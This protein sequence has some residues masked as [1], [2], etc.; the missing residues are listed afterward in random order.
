MTLP[1]L[2]IYGNCQAEAIA[3]SVIN[4]PG[5]ADR[6]RIQ[7]VRSY[8]ITEQD[9]RD[10]LPD[11]VR[12]GV[13]LLFEQ[14][15]PFVRLQDRFTFPNAK[16]V[17]FPSLDCNVLWPLRAD[18]P[19]MRPEPPAFPFGR[20]TYGDK[21]INQVVAEGLQGD[22]AWQAFWTRSSEA[23]PDM[24]RFLAVEQRRWAAAERLV[25]VQMSDVVFGDIRN[26][27]LFWTYN[28]PCRLLLCRLGA[29][30]VHAAG[31]ARTED[32]ALQSYQGALSWPFGEDYHAPVHPAVAAG[33]GLAWWHPDLAWRRYDDHFSYEQFV[34]AQIEWR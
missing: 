26:S 34:R 29:R 23:V 15:T 9:E 27:R 7:Y 11:E 12:D 8:N 2:L 18:E 4:Y 24:E 32:E 13:D 31:L 30:L 1:T 16:A 3:D 22:D 20:F 33:L 19:R 25:D 6:F 5:V 17:T 21:I 14:V 10:A 28:H